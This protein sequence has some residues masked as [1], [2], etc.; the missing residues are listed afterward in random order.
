M[1]EALEIEDIEQ[2]RREAGIDDVELRKAIGA[3]RV[4][5]IVRLTVWSNTAPFQRETVPVRITRVEGGAFR[6][7]VTAVRPS[8]ALAQVRAGKSVRFMRYHIHSIAG[9]VLTDH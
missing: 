8:R 7:R 2:L 9:K 5:D 3:L 4:G 6:G 1:R